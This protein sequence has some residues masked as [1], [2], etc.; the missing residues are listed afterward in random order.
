MNSSAGV[1]DAAAPPRQH[2]Y[3]HLGISMGP[4]GELTSR[5][6]MP[7]G[8]D[9]KTPGGIRAA[10]LALLIEGGFGGNFLDAGLFPVLDNMTV[11]VRDGGDGVA[12]A[13]AE[14][15][16]VRPG[17]R[18]AVARGHVVD[19]DDPSRLLAHAH[20]G[21]WMIQPRAEYM[22]GGDGPRTAVGDVAHRDVPKE[23]ILEAMEMHVR[24]DSGSCELRAVH[25][26]VQ[27]PEGR[28]HGG[29]HQL[30]HEAAGLAGAAAAVGTEQLRVE[31]FSIRFLAPAF[32]GPFVAT[33]SVLSR[34]PD[35][36]LCQ[37]ELIDQGADDRI[38][39]LST[40]RIR[41][42]DA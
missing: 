4:T 1:D 37:V 42:L 31:D 9:M 27:A 32:K 26:G 20:I 14:G 25:P 29:A 17:S 38:R 24:P 39:S 41:I 35:D 2:L 28:L 21:Y 19:A 11:H 7:V 23:S 22:P 40:M 16:I 3:A 30:M 10:L 18:R 33:A 6:R 36:V 15:E 5:G 13:L 34:S 8:S 12:F